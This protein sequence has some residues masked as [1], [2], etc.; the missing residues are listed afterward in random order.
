MKRNSDVLPQHCDL[1]VQSEK[2]DRYLNMWNHG[3]YIQSILYTEYIRKRIN[4]EENA[5]VYKNVR[6]TLNLFNFLPR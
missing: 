1:T 4:T 2:Y 5:N 6:G 3:Q